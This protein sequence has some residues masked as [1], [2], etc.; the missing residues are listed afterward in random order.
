[1]TEH[2][3]A[4]F[5]SDAE[6]TSAAMDLESRGIPASAIRHYRPDVNKTDATTSQ[7]ATGGFWSWLLGEEDGIDAQRN[8]HPRD[9]EIFHRGTGAGNAVLSVTL[10]DASQAE[11]AM[12]VLHAHHPLELEDDLGKAT[13]SASGVGFATE[14]AKVAPVGADAGEVIP[15]AEEQFQVGKRTV[16]SGVTRVRRYVVETPVERDVTL[17]GERVTIERRVPIQGAV[18]PGAFE[19]RTIEIHETEE[20]PVVEKSARVV[21]E[22][23]IRKEATER[24]E[25]V[26]DTV[27]REQVEITGN[28]KT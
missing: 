7:H 26:K 22:V 16:E 1:M 14:P 5:Q 8:L 23:L 28:P 20:V 2:I 24:T 21:E 4:L 19:E 3:V 25:T 18:Q 10:T 15:L 17:H 6:A 13:G 11:E 9:H 12:T 27:R